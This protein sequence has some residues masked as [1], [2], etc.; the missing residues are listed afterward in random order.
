MQLVV[1]GQT[2]EKLNV[3]DLIQQF[4]PIIYRLAV[5][6]LG[7][8][9]DAEEAAQEALMAAL[10]G[11]DS[12][13]G[14]AAFKTWLYSITLNVCR[15]RLQKGQTRQRLQQAL[16]HLLRFQAQP[17][18]PEEAATHHE[19]R[20]TVWRAI[21]SLDDMYRLPI[22]LRYYD[23]FSIAEIARHLNTSERTVYVR[24]HKAHDRLKSALKGKVEWT[25]PS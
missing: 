7:D 3:E 19:E 1:G 10:D 12:F 5:S 8:S 6:V 24:L 17:A 9:A 20:D 23:N 18:S 25:W 16:T 13:R 4:Q 11:L 14:D 15:R 22:L 21:I 2:G